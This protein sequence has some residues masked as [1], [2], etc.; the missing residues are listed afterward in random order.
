MGEPQDKP[1]SEKTVE[2]LQKELLITQKRMLELQQQQQAQQEKRHTE[3]RKATHA[4]IGGIVGV[5]IVALIGVFVYQSIQQY[6]LDAKKNRY[7]TCM[8]ISGDSGEC[9]DE[10]GLTPAELRKLGLDE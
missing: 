10:A 6:D 3:N 8:T 5:I 4:I 2:E 9:A 1:D 7:E